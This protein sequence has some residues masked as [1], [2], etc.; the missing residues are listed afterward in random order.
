M[1]TLC[2]QPL[3]QMQQTSGDS[4]DACADWCPCGPG[5]S[6]QRETLTSS[7]HSKAL[8]Q[9]CFQQGVAAPTC[10][11]SFP[12]RG[13]FDVGHRHPVCWL[14]PHRSVCRTCADSCI[15]QTWL[16][17]LCVCVCVRAPRRV[18]KRSGRAGAPRACGDRLLR[19]RR[20]LQLQRGHA[21]AL[22]TAGGEG[23]CRG[24][25]QAGNLLPTGERGGT[26]RK[27]LCTHLSALQ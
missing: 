7:M 20:A 27:K 11:N 4:A 25:A 9:S 18:D 21:A 1:C 6:V 24:H 16:C 12:L 23:R 14:P 8:H 15:P 10:C 5:C 3:S 19:P 26:A 17:Y 22:R 13:A 2:F